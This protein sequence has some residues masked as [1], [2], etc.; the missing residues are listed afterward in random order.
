MVIDTDGGGDDG[1]Y[2]VLSK[3]L[4]KIFKCGRDSAV[5]VG[6][7]ATNRRA[8]DP[9]FEMKVFYLKWREE[10]VVHTGQ[11]TIV[12]V[13]THSPADGHQVI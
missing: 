10:Q 5:I 1:G 13:S 6:S 11:C 12:I 3:A 4:F 9:V 2:I 8:D 7:A